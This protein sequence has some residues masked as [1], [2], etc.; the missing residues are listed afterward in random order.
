M[1]GLRGSASEA[2][3][4]T[5]VLIDTDPGADDALALL[6][7]LNSPDLDVRGFTTV[8]GTA[9]LAHTTRNAL[10]ILDYMGVPDVA[11]A[12]APRFLRTPP[13]DDA[14]ARR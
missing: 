4:L 9:T 7:A 5:R 2:S 3:A 11:V 10:R 8:G 6:M 1:G 13:R 14:L 12:R